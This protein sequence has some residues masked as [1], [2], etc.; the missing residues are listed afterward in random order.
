M[1]YIVYLESLMLSYMVAG[2][3]TKSAEAQSLSLLT[4]SL[5]MQ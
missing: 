4:V 3:I 2:M 5:L 1:E